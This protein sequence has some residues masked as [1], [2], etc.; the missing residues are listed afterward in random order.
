MAW[1]PKE[2]WD[3]SGVK[4][5]KPAERYLASRL[6]DMADAWGRI[7]VHEGALVSLADMAGVSDEDVDAFME[8]AQNKR[9][10]LLMVYG[11]WA[12]IVGF[13]SLHTSRFLLDR[14]APEGP[15]PPLEV[16]RRSDCSRRCRANRKGEILPDLPGWYP[17]AGEMPQCAPTPARH[18]ADVHVH[19][20]GVQTDDVCTSTVCTDHS[21]H[22]QDPPESTSGMGTRARNST[23]LNTTQ[24]KDLSLERDHISRARDPAEGRT[25]DARESRPSGWVESVKA[26]MG[27]HGELAA[28]VVRAIADRRGFG[29]DPALVWETG[30]RAMVASRDKPHIAFALTEFLQALH[31]GEVGH[32]GNAPWRWIAVVADNG[33]RKARAP[34]KAERKA[35]YGPRFDN[36]TGEFLGYG[37]AS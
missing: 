30:K 9:R 2:F 29:V 14:G 32:A 16:W 22:V 23:Q 36:E 33:P 10:P 8:R 3:L 4:H 7:P 12:Q 11:R 31:A 1:V 20:P 17:D 37:E 19:M 25:E 24:D 28:D 13:D 6:L 27:E 15:E 18:K 5:L 21:D 35:F 34:A 26:S